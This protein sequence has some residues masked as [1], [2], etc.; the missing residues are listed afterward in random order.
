[1]QSRTLQ[2]ELAHH[3]GRWKPMFFFVPSDLAEEGI[4]QKLRP[5]F[6]NR[7]HLAQAQGAEKLKEDPRGRELKSGCSLCASFQLLAGLT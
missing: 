2:Q 7:V 5:L 6:L 3:V 4:L 1:M